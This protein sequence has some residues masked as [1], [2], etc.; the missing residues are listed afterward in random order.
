MWLWKLESDILEHL[1]KRALGQGE[2][3]GDTLE[4]EDIRVN[5]EQN[6][7]LYRVRLA[8]K[9]L[10]YRWKAGVSR[11]NCYYRRVAEGNRLEYL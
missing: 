1:A 8:A 6:S 3:S 2:T 5:C 9:G 4:I 11:P 7:I 10:P